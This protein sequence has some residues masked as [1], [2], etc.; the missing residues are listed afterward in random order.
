M[1]NPAFLINYNIY[2]I[3]IHVYMIT[4]PHS[5][6]QIH[7]KFET[8]LWKQLKNKSTNKDLQEIMQEKPVSWSCN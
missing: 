8:R 4:R 6:L 2:K 3:C 1:S 7:L 5:L